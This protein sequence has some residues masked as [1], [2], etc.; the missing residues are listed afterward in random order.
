[1]NVQKET[2][3]DKVKREIYLKTLVSSLPETPGIYQYFDDKDKIIYVGKAKNLKRR[4][5]SYFNKDHKANKTKVLVKKIRNIKYIVVNTEKDALL[6]ENN[7]I[8]KHQPRYNVLLK[9]D[10]TYPSICV[11]NE[12]FPRVFKTRKIIKNGSS[13]FGPYT[14]LPTMYTLLDL[15]KKLYPIRTCKHNLSQ[16]NIKSN[17]F[18]VC[19]E[20][21]IKN[22][23]GPCE[24]LQTE[25]DYLQNIAEI[26][27]ILKG[28]TRE[29]SKQLKEKMER[30][31]EN[32]EFEKAHEYKHKL[33]LV[34]NFRSKSEVVSTLIHNIDVFSIESNG[35]KSAYINFL[36]IANGAINQAY[37]FEYKKKL[38]E[39]DSELLAMG[40][41]EMRTR[42]DS[43][44][45]EI[46]VPIPLDID[47]DNVKFTIPQRGEKKKLLD[48]SRLN[49]K[50][51]K[52]DRLKQAEKLNPAQRNIRL[53]KEIQDKLKLQKLPMHI[54]SFDNSNIQGSDPVAACI[55]FKQGKPSKKDYR[56]Y[57]IKTVIGPDDYASMH[58][59][60]IRRYSRLEKEKQPLPD[61][62]ITDG[63]KGQMEI[64]RKA[65]EEINL[66]IPIAG[67]A[68]DDRHRTSELLYGFPAQTIGMEPT[69]G[70]FKLMERIQDEVHRF[71]IQ[72]HRDKRSKRQVQSELD[73]IPG[74]GPKTKEQ[75]LK[76]FKSIKRIK[77]A[78]EDDLITLIG[79]SKGTT[80][81]KE[82]HNK[83]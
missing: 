17:K 7:L 14:H 69:S 81:W 40:I 63:G 48:L 43:N 52:A 79:H 3:E 75:L 66:K 61:L 35:E 8:K 12:F 49:V 34:E 30:Y 44:A 21:H 73:N 36:H 11:Q 24:G 19:L 16:E 59:V 53:L 33:T 74:I 10:K 13:Y 80:L 15:I 22:C 67:L 23:L 76:T 50:Q 77:E 71:A 39:T 9:D 47:L 78:S 58:E 31:A 25:E 41:I 6:L 1:M 56:K 28:N 27:E 2:K 65:L 4:V 62:I 45:N 70:L 68:K 82:I 46:V 38:N 72:F 26:K 42:F 60:V 18:K 54:E 29:I 20:Y 5:T 57:N 37:T 55:V 64:V 32:L 51:Y 83:N